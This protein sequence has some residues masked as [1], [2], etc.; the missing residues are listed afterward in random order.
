MHQFSQIVIVNHSEITKLNPILNRKTGKIRFEKE[1][2]RKEE[3]K[4]QQQRVTKKPPKQVTVERPFDRNGDCIAPAT[5]PS[6]T[7]T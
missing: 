5:T 1:I 6:K 3:K 4:E 7:T 2:G